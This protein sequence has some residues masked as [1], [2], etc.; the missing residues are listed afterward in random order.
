MED[1]QY[2]LPT[3]QDLYAALSRSNVFGKLD[4]LHVYAQLNVDAESRK[5]LTINT[6]KGL[7]SY[8][9][10]PFGVKSA[11]KI[12]QAKMEMILQGVPKCVCVGKMIFLLVVSVDRRISKSFLK[13]WRGCMNISYI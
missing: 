2:P 10:L 6:H 5:Y 11:L 1:E 4:L 8:T 3:Q 7:Y 12:F 9:K 13:C